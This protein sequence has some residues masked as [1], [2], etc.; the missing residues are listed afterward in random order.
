MQHSYCLICTSR[1]I[2]EQ[3]EHKCPQC[4]CSFHG[5]PCSIE[6]TVYEVIEEDKILYEQ[7]RSQIIEMVAKYNSKAAY[8]LGLE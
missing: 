7:A 6:K 5:D 4:R 2:I 1:Y 3:E 8:F